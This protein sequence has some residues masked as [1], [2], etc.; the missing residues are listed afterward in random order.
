MGKI[1]IYIGEIAGDF[2][3][4]IVKVITEK[5]N[6]LGYDVMTI[7]SYGSYNDDILY[8]EGEKA[9]ILLPDPS[10]F[11]GIIVAEDL[12]DI[13]GMGDELYEKLKAE[14]KCPVVYLRTKREGFYSILLENTASIENMVRHFAT[15]HGFKDI[16][17]MSGKK[18]MLDSTERLQGYYNVMQELGI[19]VTEHM[20]FHG[21][22]WRDK[23]EEAINWFMEGRDT[24]PQA[25][26]CANDYMAFSICEELRKRGVRVPEDVCV[27]G[28]D[29]VQEAKTYE[30]TLT[31][32]EVDFAGMS[33]QAMD[34]IDH[35]NRG[36]QE[37]QVQYVPAKLQLNKSCGCGEQ[38]EF[39]NVA[40]ILEKNYRQTASMKNMMLMTMEYQ[41]SIEMNEFLA[42]ADKYRDC[43]KANKIYFCFSD[44]N[45]EG[46]DEVENDSKFSNQMILTRIMEGRDQRNICNT[47]FLRKE[48]LPEVCWKKDAPN[49]FYFFTIHFKNKVYGYVVVEN[50]KEEWFD[51]Y[52]QAYLLSLANAIENGNLHVQMDKLEEI[53][54]LYQRDPLTGLYNR[55][56][57]DKLLRE[58]FTEAKE[59]GQNFGVASVDMDNLKVINDS[60][61]HAAGDD[62]IKALAEALDSVMEAGEFCARVG[63]DE[64]AAVLDMN[65]VK[66]AENFKIALKNALWAYGMMLPDVNLEASV[67]IFELAEKPSAS[68]LECLQ[69]ADMR[70]Y[71]D[72]KSRKV[73]R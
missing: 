5:A 35:V 6:A 60:L 32:L 69:Q 15:V 42:I 4:T 52:T 8:A 67:G 27:S 72:K 20:V 38:Y 10:I 47:P 71:E 22:Y 13:P 45:E 57:F 25:I 70:M 51:I 11:D 21:D 23:G 55:R 73:P 30:P 49:N 56:G 29:F 40:A 18:G 37:N 54:N 66:R 33:A 68:L 43:M 62:A 19:P 28:F 59:N 31:S 34:I 39:K 16:V 12:F 24:Y 36:M 44:S 53:R 48:L 63:G 14:A 3:H 17:Y 64:F 65:S 50:P 26:V 41:D 61:G 2:Q 9:S 1:A 58:R 7:C 46:F